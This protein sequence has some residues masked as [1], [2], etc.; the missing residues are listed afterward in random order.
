M[1]DKEIYNY[2][3]SDQRFQKFVDEGNYKRLYRLLKEIDS[4]LSFSE[5]TT[6]FTAA[7]IDIF[8]GGIV[9]TEAFKD[10][11][12][13]TQFDFSKI[14]SIESSAFEGSGIQKVVLK[15]GQ[16]IQSTA[17][18]DSAVEELYLGQG[19]SVGPGAFARCKNLKELYIN[20]SVKLSELAFASCRNLEEVVIDE[21][22][23][24]NSYEEDVFANVS[25]IDYVTIPGD[26]IGTALL[27]F[28]DNI[29]VDTLYI[30]GSR[31]TFFQTR[32]G[33]IQELIE[34]IKMIRPNIKEVEFT[35]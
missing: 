17:F 34:G 35:S 9:P 5:L 14:T 8:E 21:G 7:E 20:G 30:I 25:H 3:M 1:T 29:T 6:F 23:A 18:K 26:Y 12:D 13:L 32:Q 11:K 2:I 19:V 31:D 24:N 15:N 22:R 28:D 27:L 33:T 10:N 16:T 4:S